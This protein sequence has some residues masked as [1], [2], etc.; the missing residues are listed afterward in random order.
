MVMTNCNIIIS[1]AYG[2]TQ[3]AEPIGP[4]RDALEALGRSNL[5]A[6]A[7]SDSDLDLLLLDP[8]EMGGTTIPL[9]EGGV[10]DVTVLPA[11]TMIVGQ[12][13][14]NSGPVSL[15]NQ[16]GRIL[17]M[18]AGTTIEEVQEWNT[19]MYVPLCQ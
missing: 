11:V 14:T 10:I 19:R 9:P 6:L 18:V 13:L 15:R 2:N 12:K 16:F 7:Y 8:V 4:E 1:Y 17:Q 3:L 5:S